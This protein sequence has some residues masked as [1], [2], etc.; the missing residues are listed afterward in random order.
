MQ[1]RKIDVATVHDVEGAGFQE[2]MVEGGDIVDFAM[3]DTHETGD[4]AAQIDQCVELDG[5][6]VPPETSPRE[7][8]ETEVDRRRIERVG[9]LIEMNPKLFVRIQRPC[10]ANEYLREIGIDS[11]VAYFVRVRQRAARDA[12]SNARMIQFGMQ[13]PQARF[14]IAQALPTRKLRERHTHKLVPTREGSNPMVA[15]ISANT[16][17]EFVSWNEVERLSEKDTSGVHEPSLCV[18]SPQEYG[19]YRGRSR[20]RKRSSCS[21]IHCVHYVSIS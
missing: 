15:A 20:N 16:T 14:D 12:A 1:S 10:G 11:P 6:F 21:T 18:E 5:S 7:Q 2:Q 8:C 19:S 17:V 4:A 3:C 9:R 13:G